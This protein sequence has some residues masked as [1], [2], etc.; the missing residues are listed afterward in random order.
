V[1]LSL[2]LK[3]SAVEIELLMLAA[4][5]QKVFNLLRTV[6]WTAGATEAIAGMSAGETIPAALAVGIARAPHPSIYA[7]DIALRQVHGRVVGQIV[8]YVLAADAYP[9]TRKHA[10][11]TSACAFVQVAM[12]PERGFRASNIR[13]RVWPQFRCVAH[14]WAARQ[15]WVLSFKRLEAEMLDDRNLNSFL[16][17]AEEIRRRGLGCKLWKSDDSLLVETDSLQVAIAG[18]EPERAAFSYSRLSDDVLTS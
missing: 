17:V 2:S 5:D 11:L 14:L 4:N 1:S 12:S 3:V 8:N 13:K 9:D 18:L 10:N 7:K 16:G 6:F 15:L